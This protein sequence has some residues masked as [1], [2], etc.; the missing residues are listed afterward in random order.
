[1]ARSTLSRLLPIRSLSALCLLAACGVG[2]ACS[3]PTSGED[4]PEAIVDAGSEF[5]P[6]FELEQS[7]L[8]AE[9]EVTRLDGLLPVIEGRW[10]VLGEAAAKAGVGS[11]RL[12]SAREAD[13]IIT[14]RTASAK[15][16]NA[17]VP[18]IHQAEL[19]L[20]GVPEQ[21]SG[22][23][24]EVRVMHRM[25]AS[26]FSYDEGNAKLSDAAYASQAWE[27]SEGFG[28]LV[29]ELET[30]AECRGA[31]SVSI[32]GAKAP[33]VLE[34]YQPAPDDGQ[35]YRLAQQAFIGIKQLERYKATATYYHEFLGDTS[36]ALPDG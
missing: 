12:D 18:G 17:K 6:E 27:Q 34:R 22:H 24:G 15:L 10:V 1:M 25:G 11:I 19:V 30:S 14:S 35:S 2:A 33:E 23:L 4:F 36:S 29:A 32:T 16:V 21:C 5:S 9:R 28:V 8:Y 7:S 13:V 20:A 31:R 3:G 26:Y